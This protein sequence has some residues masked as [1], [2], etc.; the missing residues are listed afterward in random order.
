[1]LLGVSNQFLYRRQ[2]DAIG[3][4][5]ETEDVMSII[6]ASG[7]R[8]RKHRRTGSR[9]GYPKIEELQHFDCGCDTP[10][11]ESTP[12]SHLA[13]ELQRFSSLAQKSS[14]WKR[15]NQFLLDV[16]FCPL[17]NSVVLVCNTAVS[18]LYTVSPALLADVKRALHKLCNDKSLLGRPFRVHGMSEYRAVNHPLNRYPDEV[19]DKVE[20]ELDMILRADPGASDGSITVR[21]YDPEINTQEKLRKLLSEQLGT[22]VTAEYMHSSTLQRMVNDYLNTKGF[23]LSF[24]NSDHNAC[25]VCKT[26]QMTL[27]SLHSEKK[28]LEHRIS[29]RSDVSQHL[30]HELA[31]KHFQEAEVLEELQEHNLRD[32]HIRR[33]L[34]NLTTYFRGIENETATT[35]K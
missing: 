34:K 29:E 3:V 23:R 22:S 18:A 17:T 15:E 26:L 25:P 12:V 10:C 6:D 2:K 28:L 27:L 24:T 20:Q 5:S 13:A 4:E 16:L 19:R 35:G 14:S 11:L 9:K 21:V 1:M 30:S 8:E 31:N 7:M 32:A 33:L